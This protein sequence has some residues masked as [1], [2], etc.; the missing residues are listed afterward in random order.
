MVLPELKIACFSMEIGL[1]EEYPYLL[2][3]VGSAR[4]RYVDGGGLGA[5]PRRHHHR[6]PK[7]LFPA[8]S[9][10]EDANAAE[11]AR[12]TTISGPQPHRSLLRRHD[13]C[14]MPGAGMCLAVN[15]LIS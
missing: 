15:E 8:A 11:K 3:R 1:S 13:Y 4:G 10:T 9:T 14:R 6:A 12:Y 5:P 7:G 2:R